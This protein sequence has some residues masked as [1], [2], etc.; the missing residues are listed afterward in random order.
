[1]PRA[2]LRVEVA[3]T[4]LEWAIR[5]GRLPES[6]RPAWVRLKKKPTF[7]QLEAFARLTHTPLAYLFLDKPPDERLPLAD[8]RMG[9]MAGQNP[10]AE[11]LDT[12]YLCQQRQE[13]YRAYAEDEG[14]EPVALVGCARLEDNPEDAASDIRERIGLGHQ[15]GLS[16]RSWHEAF[17]KLRDLL[18]RCGVLVMAS[19]VAADTKRKLD[20]VEFRGFVLSD[21]LAPLV[22]VNRADW[23]AAQ[24]FTLAH[25][26]AHLALSRTALTDAEPV[27]SHRPIDT[28]QIERWCNRAASAILL[29]RQSFESEFNPSSNLIDEC[30]RL[31]GLFRVSAFVV[32]RRALELNLIS[33]EEYSKT[34]NGLRAF[35]EN[36]RPEVILKAE[37]RVITRVGKRF[38]SA[39]VTDTLAGNT[40]FTEAFRLLGVKRAPD[41]FKIAQKLGLPM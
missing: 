4:V 36:A 8:M 2:T 41:L 5:R 1:M 9:H 29:P 32:L 11:L 16:T 15:P 17:S 20:P 37:Q 24:I 38:A 39:V 7:K 28:I 10:S 3:D 27:G 23:R 33:E 14:L 26:I 22:F 35:V 30:R 18:E 19:S 21:K 25:E 6:K 13:W 12:V 40:R 34:R 31:A